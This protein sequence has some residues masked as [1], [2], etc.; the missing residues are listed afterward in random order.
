M[1]K[2]TKKRN[3]LSNIHIHGTNVYMT[4]QQFVDDNHL[5]GKATIREV[6]QMN[7]ILVDFQDASSMLLNKDK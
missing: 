6:I 7:N 2:A 5:F 1:I 3:L 4:H